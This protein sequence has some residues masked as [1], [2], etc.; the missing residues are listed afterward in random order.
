[1]RDVVEA[2][3]FAHP[4]TD[5]QLE[6]VRIAVLVARELVVSVNGL[7]LERLARSLR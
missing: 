5:E 2:H 1:M 4:V 3:D 6:Q 7:D